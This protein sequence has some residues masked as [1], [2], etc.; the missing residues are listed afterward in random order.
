LPDAGVAAVEWRA[1]SVNQALR[2]V[3]IRDG[4]PSLRDLSGWLRKLADELDAC[5]DQDVRT[6][7]IVTETLDGSIPP[8]RCL[9][10]NPSR[11]SVVG[12]LTM[13]AS[14]AATGDWDE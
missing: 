9:G 1:A 8:P 10:D 3:P 12:L 14:K 5:A 6:L 13:A 2:V 4:A 7:L 11:A